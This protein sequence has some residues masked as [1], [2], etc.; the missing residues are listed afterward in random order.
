MTYNTYLAEERER[1]EREKLRNDKI[2]FR[3]ILDDHISRSKQEQSNVK[4]DDLKYGELIKKDIEKFHEEERQKQ[5][6]IKKKY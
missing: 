2:R 6:L 4:L 3:K 5:A 1:L